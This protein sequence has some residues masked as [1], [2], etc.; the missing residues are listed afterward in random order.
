MKWRVNLVC[1]WPATSWG[2]TPPLLK[3]S[4]SDTNDDNCHRKWMNRLKV[5]CSYF[6]HWYKNVCDVHNMPPIIK[7][8]RLLQ[9]SDTNHLHRWWANFFQLKSFLYN[10]GQR[11]TTM[12]VMDILD[13]QQRKLQTIKNY[14]ISTGLHK[15]QQ[16][17]T[18][19]CWFHF[20]FFFFLLNLTWP[21]TFIQLG[22]IDLKWQ[23]EHRKIC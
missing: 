14:S 8:T 15:N 4:W 6:L 21:Q 23:V 22:E 18:A 13:C 2:H 16:L 5:R 3:A 17:L 1:D 12:N 10:C 11:F 19:E 7:L 9:C 20:F